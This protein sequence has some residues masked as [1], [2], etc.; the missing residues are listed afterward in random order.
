MEPGKCPAPPAAA[1]ETLTQKA[2]KRRNPG[3]RAGP[4]PTNRGERRRRRDERGS[5]QLVDFQEHNPGAATHAGHLRGIGTGRE[6]HPQRGVLA[7]GGKAKAPTRPA[8]SAINPASRDA[9][10]PAFWATV[11]LPAASRVSWA[12]P[13]RR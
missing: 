7:A 10:Q 8:A 5:G 4:D 6:V 1:A 2:R 13:A 9:L 3:G 11:A 12:G